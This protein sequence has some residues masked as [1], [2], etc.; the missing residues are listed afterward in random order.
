MLYLKV[1]ESIFREYIIHK[2]G[3]RLCKVSLAAAAVSD[4][5]R[6]RERK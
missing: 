3:Y 5:T 2:S 4:D 6:E 1:Y